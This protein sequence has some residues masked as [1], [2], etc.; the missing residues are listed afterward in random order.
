MERPGAGSCFRR[1]SFF[2][3]L[4]EIEDDYYK[5][6]QRFALA[7]RFGVTLQVAGRPGGRRSTGGNGG[8]LAIREILTSSSSVQRV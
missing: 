5:L 1:I 7:S 8:S 2:D 4:N 6:W 3:N